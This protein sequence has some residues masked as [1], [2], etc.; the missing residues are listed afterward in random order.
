MNIKNK[1]SNFDSVTFVIF[2]LLSLISNVYIIT[3]MYNELNTSIGFNLPSL[4]YV[5][6]YLL[7]LFFSVM[8]LS[9]RP[10]SNIKKLYIN[11][12]NLDTEDKAKACFTQLF[13]I[14]FLYLIY[15]VAFYFI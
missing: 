10:L 5:Y 3:T 8:E 7:M 2:A 14:W 15:N 9:T 1:N 6:T 13:I 4:E 12:N 11:D